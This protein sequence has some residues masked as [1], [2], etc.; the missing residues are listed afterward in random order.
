MAVESTIWLF[1]LLSLFC[2]SSKQGKALTLIICMFFFFFQRGACVKQWATHVTLKCSCSEHKWAV[3]KKI[4][5]SY[6]VN[7]HLARYVQCPLRIPRSPHVASPVRLRL[8]CCSMSVEPLSGRAARLRRCEVA[9][10]CWRSSP[11]WCRGAAGG[12]W[13][14]RGSS[15]SGRG[16]GS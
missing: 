2:G 7:V 11:E 12:L 9:A 1:C 5:Q 4:R 14:D 3:I 15:G 16:C 13:T 6:W 10:R 8:Y